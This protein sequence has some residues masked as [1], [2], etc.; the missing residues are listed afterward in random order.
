MFVVHLSGQVR[1]GLPPNQVFTANIQE[2]ETALAQLNAAGTTAIY[3]AVT[4]AFSQFRLAALQ[5]RV[6]LII[7]DS[8]D[9]SSQGR[10]VDVLKMAR[11]PAA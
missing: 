7:S 10:L 8:G 9:N 4:R 5:N 2:L 6:L 1:L 11:R 3:D